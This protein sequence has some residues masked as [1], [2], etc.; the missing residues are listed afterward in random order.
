MS[1]ERDEP[2]IAHPEERQQISRP[3]R[4]GLTLAARNAETVPRAQSKERSEITFDPFESAIRPPKNWR[5]NELYR[6]V[7]DKMVVK[8]IDDLTYAGVEGKPEVLS[9]MKLEL[10]QR[11]ELPAAPADLAGSQSSG[12]DVRRF[13]AADLAVHPGRLANANANGL[14]EGDIAGYRIWLMQRTV[15]WFATG[16][17]PVEK[18]IK[19]KFRGDEEAEFLLKGGV[20]EVLR[21]RTEHDRANRWRV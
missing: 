18:I 17:M 8:S 11:L 20:A 19:E 9:N 21:A 6:Q 13:L 14:K 16:A 5:G 15:F 1:T 2:P 10:K 4:D 12:I 3:V 7:F